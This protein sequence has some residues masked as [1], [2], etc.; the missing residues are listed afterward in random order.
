MQFSNQFIIKAKR[1]IIG[2]YNSDQYKFNTIGNI[3]IKDV[4]NKI[5]IQKGLCFY[6]KESIL[7]NEWNSYCWYQFSIDRLNDDLPHNVD[8]CIISC[9]YCNCSQIMKNQN[10]LKEKN[11]HEHKVCSLN[12]PNSHHISKPHITELLSELR[13]Q[14]DNLIL[15]KNDKPIDFENEAEIISSEE[16]VPIDINQIK[17]TTNKIINIFNQVK[18]FISSFWK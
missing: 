5:I 14:Y 7:F 9:Y 12:C 6:C 10:K 18:S 13:P 17:P 2:H 1:K 11:L 16:I 8:N 3:T 4:K 15:P